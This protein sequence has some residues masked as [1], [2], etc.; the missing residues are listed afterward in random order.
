MCAA[1]SSNGALLAR[2]MLDQTIWLHYGS[3]GDGV[4][5]ECTAKNM[6][7]F[8]V[9]EVFA[10][11][12]PDHASTCLSCPGRRGDVGARLRRDAEELRKR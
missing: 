3:V 9:A 1:K 12:L 11:T 8:T 6:S 4:Y 2:K 7:C 5:I 10:I